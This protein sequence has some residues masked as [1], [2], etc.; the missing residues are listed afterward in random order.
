ML[1]K[2]RTTKAKSLAGPLISDNVDSFD[3]KSPAESPQNSKITCKL[4]ESVDDKLPLII[5]SNFDSFNHKANK[6]DTLWCSASEE[7][8]MRQE[9]LCESQRTSLSSV[10]ANDSGNET[11]IQRTEFALDDFLL[12]SRPSPSV[13]CASAIRTPS[14]DLSLMSGVDRLSRVGKTDVSDD[15]QFTEEYELNDTLDEVNHIIEEGKRLVK[16]KVIKFN[17]R[18]TLSPTRVKVLQEMGHSAK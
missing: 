13:A 9:K 15:E 6:S 16:A 14:A 12:N 17:G 1:E 3:I 10:S 11:E 8:F 5:V 4:N 2:T 7:S 18:L